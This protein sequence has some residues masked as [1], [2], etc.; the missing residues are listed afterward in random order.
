M[1]P[2]HTALRNDIITTVSTTGSTLLSYGPSILALRRQGSQGAL[3][4]CVAGTERPK[5]A[6]GT[7]RYKRT[8]GRERPKHAAGQPPAHCSM[9]PRRL[10]L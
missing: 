4:G 10:K 2:I 7:E 6:A 5:R 3:G 1:V 9:S 8:A